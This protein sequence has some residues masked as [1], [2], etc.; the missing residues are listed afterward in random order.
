MEDA[1]REDCA[2]KPYL[3]E[4]SLSAVSAMPKQLA[5]HRRA[6]ERVLRYLFACHSHGVLA[7]LRIKTAARRAAVWFGMVCSRLVL[8]VAKSLLVSAPDAL[9]KFS[10]ATWSVGSDLQ[11]LCVN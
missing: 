9:L 8:L 6:S 1:T 10:P 2:D 3:N 5:F 7:G 11:E 4:S